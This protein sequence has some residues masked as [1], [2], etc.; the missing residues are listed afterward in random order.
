MNSVLRDPSVLAKHPWAP[1][2]A[3]TLKTATLDPRDPM[4][5]AA[6]LPLRLAVSQMLLGQKNAQQALDEVARQWQRIF[7]NAG[8]KG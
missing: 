1:V 2:M 3:E 7:R 6:Q 4:W 5:G 8:L